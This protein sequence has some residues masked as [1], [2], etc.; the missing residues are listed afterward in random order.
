VLAWCSVGVRHWPLVADAQKSRSSSVVVAARYR[1][2]D[3]L[4][5]CEFR[6]VKN[7]VFIWGYI[8]SGAHLACCPVDKGDLS[9][10]VKRSGRE[11]DQS[12]PV[13][14]SRIC[15]SIQPLSH[16]SSCPSA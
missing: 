16:M 13:P 4:S 8:G 11:A 6:C 1:L 14:R 12:S 7:V 10:G 3:K 2:N 9:S 15:E 5:E